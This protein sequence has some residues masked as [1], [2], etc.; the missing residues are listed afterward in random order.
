MM[1]VLPQGASEAAARRREKNA[2][3]RKLLIEA[4]I[5][6]IA[7][8]GLRQTTLDRVSELSGLS[9]GLVGFHFRSK[10]QLLVETL[11]YLMDEYRS[12]WQEALS[13][14]GL[15]PAGHIRALI[16]FDLGPTVCTSGR[17][18]VWFAFWGAVQTRPAYR[19]HCAPWDRANVV[20]IARE[21]DKIVAEGGYEDVAAE[22][23]AQGYA[24][25][26]IGLWQQFNLQPKRFDHEQAKAICLRF[27]AGIFPKHF[28]RGA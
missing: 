12:G 18:A 1:A 13:R 10:D 26:M 7:T 8:G 16:D 17:V 2:E 20:A 23:V 6:A 19:K 3:T 27:L 22:A 11:Q 21:L 28:G 15:D 5:E 25:L 24:A 9:R 4:T 14:K